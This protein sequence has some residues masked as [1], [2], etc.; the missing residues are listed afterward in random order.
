MDAS[1]CDQAVALNVGTDGSLT[2]NSESNSAIPGC[3]MTSAVESLQQL[4]QL[5]ALGIQISIDDFG[6]GYSSLRSL[7]QLPISTVKIAKQFIDRVTA[8][9]GGFEIVEAITM[10]AKQ[11]GS[12]SLRREWKPSTSWTR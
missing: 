3:V 9:S 10:V 6:T 4:H 1:G 11:L 7:H 5:R 2:L 8:G 12:G